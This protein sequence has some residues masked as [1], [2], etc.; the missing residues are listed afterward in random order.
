M[1]VFWRMAAAGT[2][3]W[4]GISGAHAEPVSREKVLAALP[5]LEAM[6]QQA[7]S[8]RAVPGL[9]IAIVHQDEVVYAKGFGL[10][11]VGKPDAVD[12]DT[13][14]QLASMSKPISATVV[15]A[16]V[17]AGIVDWDSRIADID[18]EFR[19]H[20]AYPSA[21]VTIRDLFA[22]RSGLPGTAGN[23][24]EAIGFD[25]GEVMHRLR[26]VPPS[27][28]FRA[29]YAYSNA[30]LTA[31]ALAAAR[32]T[33]KSWEDVSNEWLFRPLGMSM[34]SSRYAD[35][36]SR[37]NRAALHVDF[38]SGWTAAIKRDADVQAPAGGTSSTVRDLAQWMRLELANGKFGGETRID[39]GALAATH[40]PLMARG[41]NPVTAAASFYGLGWTVDFGRHGLAWGHAG[42]FSVGGRSLVQLYP[43]AQLGIVVLANAF[44][45]GAPEG[46]ADSYFDLVF[47]GAISKDWTTA[48][49][50]AYRG[51]FGPAIEAAKAT[52]A[53][54]PADATPAL[55]PAA[56]AGR[57]RN[58][59]VGE[60][61]VVSEN[62]AIELRLGPDGSHRY[63]MKHFDRDLFL[64][65]PDPEMPDTPSTVRFTV[66]PDAVADAVTISFLDDNGLGRLTRSAD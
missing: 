44:P 50:A 32:P 40:E 55:P 2:A 18:P 46:L 3:F 17:S 37:S 24:L 23:D 6:A 54:P 13:V 56:Y 38:G 30:G 22:H 41:N 42:A 15:A 12:A 49:D 27:S 36:V 48:W 34:T 35:F 33:G 31:G 60:A 53:K 11:E 4:F 52:Y 61:S 58:A 62:G 7:V 57:Y 9:A 66:G 14:F 19:L 59:Y 21:E 5:R 63:P 65:F 20:G 10:R 43:E 26:L 47:D 39:A 51:L 45:T 16:L 25:R 28:S 64:V 29:G 8:D 1:S